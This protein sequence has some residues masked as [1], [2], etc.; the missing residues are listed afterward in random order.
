M[1]PDGDPGGRR[2]HR[3][4]GP[5]HHLA[6]RGVAR[7]PGSGHGSSMKLKRRQLG[8]WSAGTGFAALAPARAETFPGKPLHLIEQ[9]PPCG[10]TEILALAQV[11]KQNVAL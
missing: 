11:A 4:A 1:A 3:A 9:L 5:G 7:A 2:A 8:A 10:T 6:R